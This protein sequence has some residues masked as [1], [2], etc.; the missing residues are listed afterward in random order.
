MINQSYDQ[1]LLLQNY[2]ET[3][4]LIISK[5]LFLNTYTRISRVMNT[6]V[7]TNGHNSDDD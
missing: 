1:E 4:Q 7:Y 5:H 2:S 6:S 3:L